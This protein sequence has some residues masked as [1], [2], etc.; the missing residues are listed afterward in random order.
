MKTILF[1]WQLPQNLLGVAAVLLLDAYKQ[2]FDSDL[3]VWTHYQK[4]FSSVSL[5]C[6]IILNGNL[7]TEKTVLHEIGHQKQSKILGWLYLL[8]V[9]LPSI[10]GNLLFRIKY[11]KTH[12]DYYNL[13]WEKLADRL[14]GVSR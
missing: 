4:F 9:G 2:T 1:L 7:Y 10:I 3:L 11:V 14:G 13:P 5:G 8:L 6:F 12:F